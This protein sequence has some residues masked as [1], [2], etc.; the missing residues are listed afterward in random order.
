MIL[1][2]WFLL[3]LSSTYL[4]GTCCGGQGH[5]VQARSSG[6]YD[7]VIETSSRVAESNEAAQ[8]VEPFILYMVPSMIIGIFSLLT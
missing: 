7:G 1:Y 6:G 2:S 5:D 3:G 8:A 4:R